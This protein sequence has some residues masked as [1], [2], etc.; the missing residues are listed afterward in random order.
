M[1]LCRPVLVLAGGALL[2]AGDPDAVRVD[3][4]VIEAYLGGVP[5]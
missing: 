2:A 3:P 1:G 5:A 4:R